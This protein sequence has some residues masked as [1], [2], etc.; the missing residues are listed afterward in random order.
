MYPLKLA[1]ERLIWTDMNVL[2]TVLLATWKD[3]GPCISWGRRAGSYGSTLTRSGPH[4]CKQ[5][6]QEA[7]VR[8]SKCY[9]HSKMLHPPTPQETGEAHSPFPP[10]HHTTLSPSV[11]GSDWCADM[12]LSD[13]VGNGEPIAKNETKV[14][15][16]WIR[17]LSVCLSPRMKLNAYKYKLIASSLLNLH[18]V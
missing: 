13:W 14:A 5:R 6:P 17:T 3:P 7:T 2:S 16:E 10:P 11:I 9:A 8:G 1:V 18:L 12:P 4:Q 15:T